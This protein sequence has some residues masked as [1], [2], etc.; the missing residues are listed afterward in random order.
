MAP[1][2]RVYGDVGASGQ[3]FASVEH[4]NVERRRMYGVYCTGLILTLLVLILI[5]SIIITLFL[6]EGKNATIILPVLLVLLVLVAISSF[7]FIRWQHTK[8]V[9]RRNR[10]AAEW[11]HRTVSQQQLAQQ[12]QQNSDT[13]RASWAFWRKYSTGSTR[14]IPSAPPASTISSSSNQGPPSYTPVATSETK[15]YKHT[16]V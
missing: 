4:V 11:I 10:G 12:E 7:V 15:Q 16:M 2:E 1:R 3:A 14:P 9:K 13:S 5:A 6:V 8:A